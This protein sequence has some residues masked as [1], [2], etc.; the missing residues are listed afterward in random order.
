MSDQHPTPQWYAPRGG[1][2]TAPYGTP[3]QPTAPI[4]T[5]PSS[6]VP[7]P[8]SGP[9]GPTVPSGA[10]PTPSARSGRRRTAEITAVAV[11][12]AR[13][14]TRFTVRQI[15]QDALAPHGRGGENRRPPEDERCR[16]DQLSAPPITRATDTKIAAM[17]MATATLPRFSSAG[18][19]TCG[20]SQS[21]TR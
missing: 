19:S 9:F 10:Q 16:Q 4:P 1:T 15:E 5:V 2:A 13:Q 20:V 14:L 12:A 6:T 21:I 7:P 17:K 8:P 18:K 11:L 3:T